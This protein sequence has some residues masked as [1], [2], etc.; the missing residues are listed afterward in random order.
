M[1]PVDITGSP[2]AEMTASP[3]DTTP[4]G[5]AE[6]RL[7]GYTRRYFWLQAS[8]PHDIGWKVDKRREARLQQSHAAYIH[9]YNLQMF[10]D[11]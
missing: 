7:D 4:S 6:G 1:A 5:T 8:S 2:V 11:V 10:H 3:V 9:T